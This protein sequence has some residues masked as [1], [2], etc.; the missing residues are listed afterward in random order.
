[1]KKKKN[2]TWMKRKTWD[3]SQLRDILWNTCPLFLEIVKTTKN[4]DMRETQQRHDS[5]MYGDT[6]SWGL[7][8]WL[9]GKELVC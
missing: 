6:I 5:Q 3:T 9:S 7:S 2:S 1:M 8:R 4:K